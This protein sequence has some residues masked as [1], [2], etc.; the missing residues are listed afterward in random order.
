MEESENQLDSEIFIKQE[1]KENS[2]EDETVRQIRTLVTQNESITLDSGDSIVLSN[3]IPNR[4]QNSWLS[5]FQIESF[6]KEGTR[7]E[8]Y[9]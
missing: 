5:T 7:K 4:G 9:L 3:F 1:E 6:F 8:F 2:I